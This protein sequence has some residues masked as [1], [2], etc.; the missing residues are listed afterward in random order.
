MNKEIIKELMTLAF[1]DKADTN[2]YP[3]E[4]GKAYL[5]RTV[6]LY[7]LGRVKEIK[8][9][10]VVL[11]ESSWVADTQRFSDFIKNG[12]TD[13]MEIEPIYNGVHAVNLETVVDII[14]WKNDL[15]KEQK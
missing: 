3:I 13:D 1:E 11:E 12:K 9:K 6:T 5:F 7:L 8:G 15:L 2:E 14:E 10:F 4:V